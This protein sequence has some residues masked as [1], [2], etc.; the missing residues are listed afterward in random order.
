MSRVFI[1]DYIKDPD[2]ERTIL[3]EDVSVSDMKDAEV[4]LVWHKKIDANYLDQFPKV[5]V[6]IRY[7]VG[8]D[9]I[10]F[11]EASKR[12]ILICNTPDYGVE[13]VS[14]TALGMVLS[15][16]RNINRY[17]Y[18]AKKINDGTWQENIIKDIK[19]TSEMQ[20]GILGAGR[21]GGSLILK[22]NNI[23]FNTSFFDPYV[24]RGIEKTY[25]SK[26]YDDLSNF[27]ESN[28]IISI[29]ASQ[30]DTSYEMVNEKFI[31]K[32]KEGSYLINTARGKIIK[33]VDL[34]IEPLKS[35]KILGIALDVLPSEPPKNSELID[36]WRNNEEWLDNKVIINPHAGYYSKSSWIEMR[37]K[38]AQNA[39][40][41]LDGLEP[42]NKV[43][44]K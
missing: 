18:K 15:L 38:A 37:I 5:S 27:I 43:K 34:F 28:D 1:T 32:M 41:V 30:T 20:I 9:N 33:D 23:G 16:I 36:A 39:K 42:F 26:R 8:C 21:I 3:N 35:G 10:D 31:E 24:N 19:R 22:C 4:L 6:L 7:G 29:N 17:D 2:L 44:R 12:N 11:D 40:R 13:E 25:S 14:D